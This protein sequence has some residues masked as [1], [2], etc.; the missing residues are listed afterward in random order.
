MFLVIL[1]FTGFLLVSCSK[2]PPLVLTQKGGGL[3]VSVATLGEYP[4]SICRIDLLNRETG[5]SVWE[6]RA[7]GK[8]PQLW[9]FHLKPG[10]NPTEPEGILGGQYDVVVPARKEKFLLQKGS[11]YEISVWNKD[12]RRSEKATFTL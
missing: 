4:T 1:G 6:L 9:G 10:L 7:K 12:C 2:K 8:V 5:E 11:R 3:E